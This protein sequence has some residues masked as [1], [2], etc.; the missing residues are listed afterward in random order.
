MDAVNS[1]EMFAYE[2][3]KFGRTLLG[4][5]KLTIHLR[6]ANLNFIVSHERFQDFS[7]VFFSVCIAY[8]GGT[9]YKKLEFFISLDLRYSLDFSCF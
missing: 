5:Q 1:D 4:N 9:I 7:A 6:I 8:V 3:P 2:I